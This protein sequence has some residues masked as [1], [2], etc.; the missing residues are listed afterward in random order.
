MS[1]NSCSDAQYGVGVPATRRSDPNSRA[2]KATPV[3][4]ASTTVDSSGPRSTHTTLP[5]AVAT[6]RLHVTPP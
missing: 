4:N 5:R 2:S 1:N 3:T 6:R